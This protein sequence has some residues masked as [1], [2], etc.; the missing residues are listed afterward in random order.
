MIAL[1][2]MEQNGRR[3]IMLKCAGCGE[4]VRADHAALSA[5]PALLLTLIPA[6][7][8]TVPGAFFCEAAGCD[9][10]ARAGFTARVEARQ[11]GGINARV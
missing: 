10:D 4:F 1:I 6:G 7:R 8:F 2:E 3:S 5:V 9:L 11:M